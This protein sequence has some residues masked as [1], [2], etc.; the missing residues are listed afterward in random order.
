MKFHFIKV[1][2]ILQGWSHDLKFKV[3]TNDGDKQLLRV[4][5]ANRLE[6][7]KAQYEYMKQFAK[8]SN[9]CQVPIEFGSV[10]KSDYIFTL[11]T[12]V[13]G[14]SLEKVIDALSEDQQYEIGIQ[15][16]KILRA[17]HNIHVDQ[18][19]QEVMQRLIDKKLRQLERY[20]QSN[21]RMANDQMMIDYVKENIHHISN[22]P[23]VYQHGDFHIGNFIYTNHQNLAIIDFDRSDMGDPYEEFL[24]LSF[25]TREK[26]IPL[27][28]GQIHSYFQGTI[29]SNFWEIL[30]VYVFHTSLYSIIWAANYS[31]DD[32]KGMVARYEQVL[33]DYENGKRLKPIWWS[34]S[35]EMK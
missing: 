32:V 10:P 21:N 28:I 5:S 25:F 8:V 30:K 18:H 6:E 13:E 27:A 20:E 7:R 33:V 3:T 35:E 34:A 9:D 4:S 15:A 2:H 11:L 24:K 29:P 12:Y 26:S 19:H 23:A 17:F 1:E 16:G 14:E 31:E 22:Q